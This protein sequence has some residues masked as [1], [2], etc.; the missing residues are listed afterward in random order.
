M[1]PTPALM[2][3]LNGFIYFLILLPLKQHHLGQFY[4]SL[5][6]FQNGIPSPT[7]CFAQAKTDFYLNFYL[8]IRLLRP[9]QV[10]L[11]YQ[12][13]QKNSHMFY[14]TFHPEPLQHKETSNL[15]QLLDFS[16]SCRSNFLTRSLSLA[17]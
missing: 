9:L 15:T 5:Y 2:D 1:L 11:L 6:P 16:C 8:D 12:N 10:Q 7:K 4:T 13:L 14:P 17:A 3:S